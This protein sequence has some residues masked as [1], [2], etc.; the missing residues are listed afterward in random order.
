MGRRFATEDDAKAA[1]DDARVKARHGEYIDRNR[2]TVTAYLDEWID[3]HA[4]EIKPRTLADYRACIRLYA[5]PRI[6][7]RRTGSRVG[8]RTT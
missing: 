3:A 8:A 5:T 7:C 4:M 6:G 2:I 1:R